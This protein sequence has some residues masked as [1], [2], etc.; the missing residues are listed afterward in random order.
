MLRTVPVTNIQQ[1]ISL[2]KRH[3]NKLGLR[4]VYLQH[5]TGI[6]VFEDI[7]Q[8]HYPVY[9]SYE[10]FVP[11]PQTNRVCLDKLYLDNVKYNVNDKGLY[12]IST[13]YNNGEVKPVIEY[14]SKN[15]RLIDFHKDLLDSIGFNR[16]S[17][18]PLFVSPIPDAAII[19]IY[20]SKI[21]SYTII[22]CGKFIDKWNNKCINHYSYKIINDYYNEVG[23]LIHK[24][25]SASPCW[26]FQH[27]DDYV[28]TLDVIVNNC[29]VIQSA[30]KSTSIDD[31]KT[32]F[33]TK[34]NGNYKLILDKLFGENRVNCE[35]ESYLNR[36]FTSR[37]G[38]SIDIVALANAMQKYN[39]LV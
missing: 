25:K 19:D 39:I 32:A 34:D 16:Y 9:K 2:L 29:S 20:A 35:L 4:E 30:E 8:K 13:N 10:N 18:Q 17:E 3:L 1:T 27:S 15:T 22:K 38:G 33:N 36:E 37:I 7:R 31:M 23:F 6:L 11:L 12:C 28:N 26:T 14:I 21:N 5:N 24:P